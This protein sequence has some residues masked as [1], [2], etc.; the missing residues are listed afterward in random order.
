MGNKVDDS[1]VLDADSGQGN[2]V[3]AGK[4]RDKTKR[5]GTKT[6]RVSLHKKQS[7]QNGSHPPRGR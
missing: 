1:A 6:R 5:A 7:H 2:D 4:R 3:R